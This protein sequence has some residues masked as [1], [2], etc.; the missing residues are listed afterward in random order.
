MDRSYDMN[1]ILC[2][3]VAVAL[4]AVCLSDPALDFLANSPPFKVALV[5]HF[6]L[7][8]VLVA[9]FS[10]PQ[11]F[12]RRPG[13]FTWDHQFRSAGEASG[14]IGLFLRWWIVLFNIAVFVEFLAFTVYA[15]PF[16]LG[17]RYE[18]CDD[19]EYRP[20]LMWL[21]WAIDQ[22]GMMI[23]KMGWWLL[24]HLENYWSEIGTALL[25]YRPQPLSEQQLRERQFHERQLGSRFARARE[26]L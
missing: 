21:G 17:W 12:T 3:S 7:S 5:Y 9:L 19:P 23:V 8:F 11:A 14:F 10:L 20:L 18:H 22:M 6:L 4:V 16:M 26:E 15:L 2:I 1:R 25:E 24:W 13:T